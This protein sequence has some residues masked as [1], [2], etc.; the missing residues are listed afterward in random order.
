MALLDD[1]S[2]RRLKFVNTIVITK[3]KHL[4]THTSVYT[5]THNSLVYVCTHPDWMML[6]RLQLSLPNRWM[7]QLDVAMLFS[8]NR[9]RVFD[10]DISV[11][12][13]CTA[14]DWQRN[15]AAKWRLPTKRRYRLLIK[16]SKHTHAY[17]H[18]YCIPRPTLRLDNKIY[19]FL[20]TRNVIVKED[21]NLHGNNR[22]PAQYIREHNEKETH[23][24]FTIQQGEWC[25]FTCTPNG[26]EQRCI[27]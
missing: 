1:S 11:W 22:R 23:R 20:L 19:D 12:W 8:S 16:K 26:Y 4:N 25:R 21:P 18:K 17:K 9:V 7:D 14:A 2:A 13:M 10:C 3:I 5:F 6:W 15:S 24:K 27:E